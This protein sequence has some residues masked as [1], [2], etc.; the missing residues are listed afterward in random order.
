MATSE[1]TVR[2]LN[3]L[4]TLDHDAA[5]AYSTAIQRVRSDTL[6]VQL[7]AF[8]DDHRR[9]LLELARIV[10]RLGGHAHERGDL[11]G[12]LLRALTAVQ[13]MATDDLALRALQ[14]SERLARNRYQAALDAHAMPDE[15]LEIVRRHRDDVARHHTWIRRALASH[16]YEGPQPGM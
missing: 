8:L 3:D 14:A 1:E 6:R 11:T 5:D 12:L 16:S 4:V 2:R 9:H 13:A 15:Y 10:S 7:Q